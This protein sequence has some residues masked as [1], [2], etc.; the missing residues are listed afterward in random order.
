[1]ADFHA[2]HPITLIMPIIVDADTL[3]LYKKQFNFFETPTALADRMAELI[4]DLPENSR[5]LEPSA[6]MGALIRACQRLIKNKPVFYDVCEPQPEFVT[7]LEKLGATHVGDDFTAYRPSP[8]YDG[9]IM[10]PPYKNRMAEKHLDHAWNC[11][12]PGGR[13]V[14]LVGSGA[15]EYIDSEYEGYVFERSLI[16]RKTFAETPIETCLYLIHKPLYA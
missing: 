6:G 4:D 7:I 14:A 15:V 3:R 13:I 5:I 8:I 16:P 1:M 2:I 10:N 11:C 12:K 9:I